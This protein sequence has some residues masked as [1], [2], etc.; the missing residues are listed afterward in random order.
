[1]PQSLTTAAALPAGTSGLLEPGSPT[2]GS[3]L[4]RAMYSQ[5]SSAPASFPSTPVAGGDSP[6][7]PGQGQPG[8]AELHSGRGTDSQPRRGS[9]LQLSSSQRLREGADEGEQNCQA[10]CVM[11]CCASW[12]PPGLLPLA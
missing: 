11:H 9:R 8:L 10:G 4:A 6:F 1:M 12:R 2:L 3:P 7:S 5:G